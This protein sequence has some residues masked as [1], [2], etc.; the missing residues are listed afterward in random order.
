MSH[1]KAYRLKNY[2]LPWSVS[3]LSL[4]PI[5]GNGNTSPRRN[6]VRIACC[7]QSSGAEAGIRFRPDCYG[8]HHF[9]LAN[10]P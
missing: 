8:D 9:Q 2:Q 10:R 7:Y 5:F 3:S 1:C 4:Q 6:Q